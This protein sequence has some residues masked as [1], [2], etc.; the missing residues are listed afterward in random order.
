M[1]N[2]AIPLTRSTA[3]RHTSQMHRVQHGLG[4]QAI[5]Q[6]NQI[7]REFLQCLV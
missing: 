5:N 3:I 7:P 6:Q 4:A 2:I 1:G